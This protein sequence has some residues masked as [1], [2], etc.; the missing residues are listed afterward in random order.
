VLNIFIRSSLIMFIKNKYSLLNRNH[1]GRI[2][3]PLLFLSIIAGKPA[4]LYYFGNTAGSNLELQVKAAY[5]INFTRFVYWDTKERH[6]ITS[7]VTVC[8]LGSDP[9]GDLLDDFSKRKT[10]GPAVF[11]NKIKNKSNYITS[12]QLLFVSR[13]EQLQMPAILELLKGTNVLTVSDI[14]GFARHGGMIGFFLKDGRVKIE[15]NMRAINRTGLKISAKLLEI[16][17]IVSEED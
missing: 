17:R 8:V 2:L 3:F 4:S 11:V 5:I 7:P 15:I 9:I 14:D 10:D 12:C 6:Q 16:A 13:S 1:I